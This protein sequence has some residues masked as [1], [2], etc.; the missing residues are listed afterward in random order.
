MSL[1]QAIEQ[2]MKSALKQGDTIKLSVLRMLVSSIRMLM[3]E[4][5]LKTAED[6]DTLRVIQR[7]IK[8]RKESIEQ[9]RKGNRSDLA[10]KEA[11]ELK[12]LEGYMP[13]QLSEEEALAIVKE[14]ICQSGAV[15][16]ADTG[17]VMKLVMDK[18]KGKFDGKAVNQLVMGFL[19]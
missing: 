13:E 2:N 15:T 3:L 8:Q 19:K 14:C 1:Y 9:F 4:K 7:H 12:I 16:K 11:A 18:V 10:E 17:K 6:D 5:N